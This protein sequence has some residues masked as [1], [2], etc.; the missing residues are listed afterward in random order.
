MFS[1]LK[2]EGQRVEIRVVFVHASTAPRI[3]E[4]CKW[5]A[6][7]LPFVDHVALMGLENTGFAIANAEELWIDPVD[8]RFLDLGRVDGFDQDKAES[9]RDEG[10]VILRRLLASKRDTLEAL[11]LADRLFDACP[12]LVECLWKEGG[13][14]FGVGSIRDCRAY[15][16]LACGL[17][18]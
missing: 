5:F 3:V 1:K 17:A 18:I 16:A 6:R 2:N 7:N 15:S 12:R 13:H 11:E 9:K 14:V 8:Y 4:T 10:A